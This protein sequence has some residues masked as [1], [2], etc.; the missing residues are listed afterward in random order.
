M[1]RTSSKTYWSPTCPYGFTKY[2][3]AQNVASVCFY[4]SS[5]K[6]DW[7]AARRSCQAMTSHQAGGGVC[8]GDLASVLN[9]A[10]NQFIM[11]LMNHLGVNEHAW[12]GYNDQW[13]EGH[14]EWSDGRQS[15]WTRFYTGEPNNGGSVVGLSENC[16]E[17][18]NMLFGYWNDRDC[19][20]R[21][22]YVCKAYCV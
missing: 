20:D 17:I 16:I 4:V 13:R 18:M 2:W 14:Y 1:A 19:S 6:A 21:K 9:S 12:L 11:T 3:S 5:V 10:E 15:G 7:W 22:Y 8:R